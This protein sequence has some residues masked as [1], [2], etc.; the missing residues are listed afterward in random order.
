[1]G[2]GAAWPVPRRSGALGPGSLPLSEKWALM[3][4]PLS[5]AQAYLSI[6]LL[7]QAT[8]I[9]HH[10]DDLCWTLDGALANAPVLAHLSLAWSAWGE[11]SLANILNHHVYIECLTGLTG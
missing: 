9:A 5:Q 7:C 4:S 6:P 10:G 3:P 1:M 8:R 11:S 2:E